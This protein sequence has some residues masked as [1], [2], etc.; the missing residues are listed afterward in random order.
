MKHISKPEPR[1]TYPT[2]ATHRIPLNHAKHL[3]N[4]DLLNMYVGLCIICVGNN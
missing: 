4:K 3:I 2:T 1:Y